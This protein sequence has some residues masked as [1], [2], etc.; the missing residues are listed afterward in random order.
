[1]PTGLFSV[2]DFFLCGTFRVTTFPYL[3][4]MNEKLLWHGFFAALIYRQTKEWNDD[5]QAEMLRCSG[6][7]SRPIFRCW[8]R[9]II[10]IMIF[11]IAQSFRSTMEHHVAI[12]LLSRG[13][14]WLRH[15]Y[16]ADA[17]RF[18]VVM[19]KPTCGIMID[20]AI[21][22]NV[23]HGMSEKGNYLRLSLLA[24]FCVFCEP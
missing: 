5:K 20:C 24:H 23:C 22:Y 15:V 10:F 14:K 8:L 6:M 9:S 18:N 19:Q 3:T 21:D 1:M 2:G 17:A 12:P 11:N 16:T 13:M 4:D 7:K